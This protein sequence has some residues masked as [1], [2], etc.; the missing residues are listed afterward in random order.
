MLVVFARKNLLRVFSNTLRKARI[1]KNLCVTGKKIGK[2][3]L[4]KIV[5]KNCQQLPQKH[6]LALDFFAN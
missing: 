6:G 1:H 2:N 3:I 4:S 5:K